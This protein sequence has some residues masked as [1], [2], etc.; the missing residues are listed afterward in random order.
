MIVKIKVENVKNTEKALG[1]V[2]DNKWICNNCIF[3]INHES[4]HENRCM[5]M[6][7][8]LKSISG[9]FILT[10]RCPIS[11]MNEFTFEN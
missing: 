4:K 9:D 8:G 6:Q 10:N 5:L 3:G 11:E 7:M 1:P 2:Q